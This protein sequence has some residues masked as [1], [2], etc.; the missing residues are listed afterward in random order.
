MIAQVNKARKTVIPPSR[1]N[2]HLHAAIPAAPSIPL[3]IPADISPE[4]APD[5]KEPENR[6]AVRRE[7]SFFVY[8]DDK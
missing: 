8:H 2:S 6:I 7:S 1:M 3:V 5:I 4:K